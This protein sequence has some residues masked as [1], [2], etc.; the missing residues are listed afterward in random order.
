MTDTREL[1]YPFPDPSADNSVVTAQQADSTSATTTQPGPGSTVLV[2]DSATSSLRRQDQGSVMGQ[3][4]GV[5][6]VIVEAL[7]VAVGGLA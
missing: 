6:A 2:S 7:T 3:A 5:I 4:G 1:S